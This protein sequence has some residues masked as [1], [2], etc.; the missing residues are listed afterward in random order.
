LQRC[1]RLPAETRAACEMQM[2]GQNTTVHGSVSGGGVLRESTVTVPVGTPGST[3]TITPPAGGY[4]TPGHVPA[5]GNSYVPTPTHHP[6]TLMPPAAPS[7]PVSP[8]YG[9]QPGYDVKRPTGTVRP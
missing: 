9:A 6:S 2:H 3:T 4:Q 1:E 7:Q 8:P 5:V